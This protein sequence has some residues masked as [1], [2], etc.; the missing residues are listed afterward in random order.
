MSTEV[1]LLEII[2]KDQQAIIEN[3]TAIV[4]DQ[5]EAIESE[6]KTIEQ[7]KADRADELES[8]KWSE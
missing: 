2:V 8:L 1:E 5:Q 3:L 7:M 6:K 4:K